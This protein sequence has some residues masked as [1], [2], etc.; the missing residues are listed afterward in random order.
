MVRRPRLSSARTASTDGLDLTVQRGEVIGVVG[1]SGTGQD[2]AAEHHHRSATPDG[3]EVR[4]FGM[5]PHTA[6]S[7]ERAEIER[8]WGVLFQNGA[9]FSAL[10]VKDNVAAPMHEHTNLPSALI[11]DLADLKIS[12]AGLPPRRPTNSRRSFPAAC[13]SGEPG[14]GAGARPGAAVPRRAHRRARSDRRRGLRRR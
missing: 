5:N 2:G 1:G 9:L 12:M 4:V 10:T 8:R 14:R 7:T 11:S 13:A 6:T 3:G